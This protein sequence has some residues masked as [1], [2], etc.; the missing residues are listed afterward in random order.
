MPT[1][2][3]VLAI[4]WTPVISFWFDLI[5]PVEFCLRLQ[6]VLWDCQDDVSRDRRL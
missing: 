6:H 4:V 5:L 1:F 2:L 3:L